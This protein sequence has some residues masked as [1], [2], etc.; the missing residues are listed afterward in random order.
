MPRPCRLP[1][2]RV[3]PSPH[4]WLP[5]RELR[6]TAQQCPEIE[7]RSA[8][9]DRNIATTA[10]RRDHAVGHRDPACDVEM[11][12]GIEL[13]VKMVRDGVAQRPIR[14]CAADVEA[15]VDLDRVRVDDLTREPPCKRDGDPALSGSGRP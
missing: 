12:I 1:E 13:I 7:I 4:L 6:Q 9:D 14:F 10:N 8:N 2:D 11:L 3:E 15:A 5:W